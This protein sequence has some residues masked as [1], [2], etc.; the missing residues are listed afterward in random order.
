MDS[1]LELRDDSYKANDGT[2]TEYA[3][4]V[5]LDSNTFEVYKGFNDKKLTK[6]DRFYIKE[7]ESSKAM[8]GSYPLRMLCVFKF[9]ELPSDEEFLNT[10]ELEEETWNV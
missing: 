10:V 9:G 4:V 3:Y 5:D 2:F 1:P 8:F 7:Q 6:S